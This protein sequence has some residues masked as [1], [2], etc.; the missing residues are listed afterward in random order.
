[1]QQLFNTLAKI[2][3]KRYF[4]CGEILFFE[5]MMPTHLF[6]LLHGKV[7]LYKVKEQL[8]SNQHT[9]HT[10]VAPQFIAEMPFFMQTPYPANAECIQPCEIISISLHTFHTHCLQDNQICT[11][12]ITSLCKKIQILESHIA[13]QNKNLQMRVLEYLSSHAKTL[14]TLTQRQIAQNLNIAPES[15]SRT[16]KILKNQGKIATQKGKIMLLDSN[17][18]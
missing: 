9:L 6:L 7:R 2:G 5:G 1:M 8:T 17:T 18:L 3:H 10:L 13:T 14:S 15:L 16:L 12:F 4:T 11:L